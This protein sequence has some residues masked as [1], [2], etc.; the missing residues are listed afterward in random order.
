M[1]C[2]LYIHGSS[3]K[4]AAAQ[5]EKRFGR[6][7]KCGKDHRFAAFEMTLK[8]NNEHDRNKL[9]TYPDGFLYYEITA[10]LEI[11]EDH[12]R[13]TDEILKMLWENGMPAVASCDY[14]EELN[15]YIFSL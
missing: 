7:V 2:R 11:Y 8:E 15:R 3:V 12:I 6:A 5:F 9:R 10:E 14:E 13:M 1:F 4:S